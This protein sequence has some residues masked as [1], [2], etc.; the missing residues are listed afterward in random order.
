MGDMSNT[1]ALSRKP[2][3][4]RA[5]L[6]PGPRKTTKLLKEAILEAAE[7][8]GNISEGVRP[9][10]KDGLVGYLMF[11]AKEQP[12]AYTSLLA[13]VLPMQITGE[14]GGPLRIINSEM[15][16]Q[17]AA[18]AYADTIRNIDGIVRATEEIDLQPEDYSVVEDEDPR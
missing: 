11:L 14:G 3:P 17:E 13:R 18:E 2:R 7:R 1:R 15:T 10:G 16:A 9:T 8:T 12:K 5:G 6:G 4:P